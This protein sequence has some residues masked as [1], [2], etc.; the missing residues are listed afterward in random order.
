MVFEPEG[1]VILEDVVV[2]VDV[3]TVVDPEDVLLGDG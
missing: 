3:V 2:V 1:P